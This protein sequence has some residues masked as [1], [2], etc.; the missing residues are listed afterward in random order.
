MQQYVSLIT[1][2]TGPNPPSPSLLASE[3]S[4]VAALIAEK[5]YWKDS[6][7]LVSSTDVPSRTYNKLVKYTLENQLS[8]I[9]A[10]FYAYSEF[11]SPSS[12]FASLSRW[13]QYKS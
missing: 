10:C 8:W 3:K 6:A 5:A 2:Y 13:Q 11:P 7:I 9:I 1:L 4:S 12:S